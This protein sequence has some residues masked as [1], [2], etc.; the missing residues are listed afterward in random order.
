M[1][2]PDTV[3]LFDFDFQSIRDQSASET[4]KEKQDA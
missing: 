3:A 4:S 1:M 2:F